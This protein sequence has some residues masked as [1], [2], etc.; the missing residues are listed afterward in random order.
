ME[1]NYVEEISLREC[2]EILF[3]GKKIIIIITLAAVLISVLLSFFLI[4]PTYEASI[5]LMA[6]AAGKP[7]VKNNEEGISGFLNS[8][9]DFP[10][11]TIETYKEQI[12]NPVIL[13]EVIDELKLDPEGY[14][15]ESLSRA[16]TLETINNTN[17][18]K[19]KVKNSDPELAADI[20]N[21][22]ANIFTEFVTEEA[23]KQAR[24]SYEFLEKQM[25]VEKGKLDQALIAYKEFV[26]KSRGV[27]ELEAEVNSKLQ[28][29]TNYK[30]QYVEKEVEEKAKRAALERAHEELA[31]TE[32]LLVTQKSLSEDAFLNQI[33]S[34]YSD[35]STL[36]VGQL[37]ME[38]EEVNPNYLELQNMISSLEIEL[39]MLQTE[40]QNLKL[41]IERNSEELETLQA[42]LAEKQHQENLL[43]Q[44]VNL[45]QQTYNSFLSKYE[46]IRITQSSQVGD[47]SIIVVSP[48]VEPL[49]PVSPKK[50]LNIAIAG[51]LGVIISVVIVF[52]KEYWESTGSQK[53]GKGIGT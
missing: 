17:L 28:L 37:I 50:M 7:Q 32:K 34:D 16:I 12:K 35:K 21:T 45:A 1:D 46:E 15:R 11:M 9:S 14:T 26:A 8:I 25:N 30:T 43:Q 53:T 13:Q 41:Q 42:E 38:S 33:V 24:K 2:I 19:I 47:A 29:I 40:K 48:A 44:N 6:I 10:V 36:D 51:V 49:E 5:T 52:F 39:A 20:V 18:I 22:I 3:K 27:S 4:E 23:K 31:V